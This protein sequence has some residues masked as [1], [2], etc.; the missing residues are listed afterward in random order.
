MTKTQDNLWRNL[1]LTQIIHSELELALEII[2][3]IVF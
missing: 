1:V 3:P 2:Y